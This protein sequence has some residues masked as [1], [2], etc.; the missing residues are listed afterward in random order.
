M[1]EELKKRLNEKRVHLTR[2]CAMHRANL[3]EFKGGQRRELAQRDLESAEAD[4]EE[5]NEYIAMSDR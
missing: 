4:L 5:T 3:Q 1:S 2:V